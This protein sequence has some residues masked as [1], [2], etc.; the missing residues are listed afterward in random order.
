[1]LKRIL[2]AYKEYELLFFEGLKSE[3]LPKHQSWDH[4]IP[5]EPGKTLNFEPIYQ[6]FAAKLQHL[7]KYIDKNLAKGFI[8]S[9]T[10]SATSLT[11]FVSK[12]DRKLRLCINYRML[13]SITIKDKYPLPLINELHDRLQGATIFITLNIKSAYNFIKIKKGK[14]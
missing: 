1:M 2:A 12:K 9:F 4:E 13:N 6:Q 11:L 14:K 5:L 7:K 10:S 3:A 8:Q